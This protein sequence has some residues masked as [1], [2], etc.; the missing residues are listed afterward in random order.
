MLSAATI[1]TISMA[2]SANLL[3]REYLFEYSWAEETVARLTMKAMRS[4]R[5]V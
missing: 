1:S 4:A 3:P 5:K 2:E